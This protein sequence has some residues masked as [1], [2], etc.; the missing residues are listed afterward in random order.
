[1]V[2]LGI[3]V[4]LPVLAAVFPHSSSLPQEMTSMISA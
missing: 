1:M 2:M 3:A 4:R